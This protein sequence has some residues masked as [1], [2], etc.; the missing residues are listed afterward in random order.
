MMQTSTVF[1]KLRYGRARKVENRFLGQLAV[2]SREAGQLETRGKPCKLCPYSPVTRVA[3]ENSQKFFH[4]RIYHLGFYFSEQ[5]AEL[6]NFASYLL[7][8]CLRK[9]LKS[10]MF[11]GQ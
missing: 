3:W 2:L 6:F 11:Y 8:M 4:V 1:P 5:L 7:Y 10:C 9:E